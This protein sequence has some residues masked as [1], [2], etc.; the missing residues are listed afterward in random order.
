MSRKV[1]PIFGR[2][3]GPRLRRDII[4]GL[5]DARE[6]LGVALLSWRPPGGLGARRRP[7]DVV[8]EW[9]GLRVQ[10]RAAIQVLQ[11]VDEIAGAIIDRCETEETRRWFR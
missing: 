5:V 7:E 9:R 6:S 11:R 3:T 8:D 1:P 10:V 2:T 4:M